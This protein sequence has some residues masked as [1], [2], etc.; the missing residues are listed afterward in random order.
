MWIV[1]ATVISPEHQDIG[2]PL[3]VLVEGNRIAA[4]ID[5]LPGDAP[6]ASIVHAEG[7]FLIPG[8]IDSHVHLASIPGLML[9]NS[10]SWPR[11]I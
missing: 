7:G 6:S 1:G 10:R 2:R 8:L 3:N 11:P 5:T 9:A 4:V